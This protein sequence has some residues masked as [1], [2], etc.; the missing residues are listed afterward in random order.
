VRDFVPAVATVVERF[1]TLRPTLRKVTGGTELIWT[2]D[3]LRSGE[4]RVLNYRIR[5]VVDIIGTLK[6]PVAYVKYLDKKKEV[7]KAVSKVA[8][9]KASV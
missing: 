2:L 1:D 6:L 3:S 9:I 7:N 8:Y 4:E 5:P